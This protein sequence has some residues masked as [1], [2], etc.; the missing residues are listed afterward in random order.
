MTCPNCGATVAENRRFCG[1]CGTALTE[2][3]AAAAPADG[4]SAPPMPSGATAPPSSWGPPA[5]ASPHWGAPPAM[6]PTAPPAGAQDPFAPPDLTPPNPWAGYDAQAQY[7]PPG[8]PGS[9]PP[10][11]T[12]PPPQYPP[13]Q[14]PGAPPGQYPPGQYPPGQYP[15]APP[16]W[17]GYAPP[18]TNGLAVA[19]FVLGLAGWL[20]CGVGSVVAIILGFVSRNQIKQSWGRQTGSGLAT[21]GIALGFIGASFWLVILIVNLV[22]AASST[23]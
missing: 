21:A 6:P 15:G 10:G 9:P 14:Y 22:H 19:A 17:Y 4:T 5:A 12:G 1:K 16:G 23:G 2:P 3:A 7:P 20:L 18:H 8:Y 13:G 11:Y